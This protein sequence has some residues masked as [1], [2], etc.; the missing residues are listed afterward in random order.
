MTD[1]SNVDIAAK[2][3]DPLFD[4]V[5][6][7]TGFGG[8][9]A[10]CRLAQARKKICVLERGRRYP[11]ADFPRPA[12]RPDYL[13]HTSRWAWV[14]DQGLWDIKDL[15]GTLS[16]QAAGYGGGSLVYANVHLRPPPEVF[17]PA[18]GWPAVYTRQELD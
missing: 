18:N 15:Q 12:E 7:G 16:V 10:A 8:A 11:K 13:P 17:S 4:A 6:V 3:L 2:A 5:V 9:V 14:L 1:V